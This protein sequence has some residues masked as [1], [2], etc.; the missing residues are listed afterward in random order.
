[1]Y[2][3]DRLRYQSDLTPRVRELAILAVAAH[4][5][6]EFERYAHEAFGRTVGLSG[7]EMAAIRDGALADLMDPEEIAALRLTSS[8]ALEPIPIER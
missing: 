6:S 7:M 1:M 4:Y 3:R 2:E 5:D 8:Q